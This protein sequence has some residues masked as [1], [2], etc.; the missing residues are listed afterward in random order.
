MSRKNVIDNNSVEVI[1]A[2]TTFPYNIIKREISEGYDNY[3]KEIREIQRYYIDYEQGAV[4][5]PEGSAGDYI[6][7]DVR[8]KQIRML[9]NK[10]A[11]F[12]FSQ[13]PDILVQ[14]NNADETDNDNIQKLQSLVDKVLKKNNFSSL[15]LKS[16]KDCFIGKRIACLVDFSEYDGIQIHFYNSMQ[17]YYETEYDSSRITKFVSF[18]C[19]KDLQSSRQRRFLLKKYE[20]INNIIYTETRLYDGVGKEVETIV[21]RKQTDLRD[22][23][24]AII[25]NDGTLKDTK[26]ISEVESLED[27]ESLF[28]KLA[29]AD[30][31]SERKGMNPTRY[32]IDMN[33]KCTQN[34]SSSAGSYWDLHTDQNADNV[35]PSVG[36]LAP[37]LN[38]SEPLK[39]TLERIRNQ[40]Y[41][42]V[43][44]PDINSESL[45]G[46]VTSGKSMKALYWG[47]IVR[48][49][50]KMIQ[51][52]PALE[53]IIT[54]VIELSLLNVDYVKNIYHINDL[55]DISYNIHIEGNYAL[56]EDEMEEKDT[57]MAEINA[58]ARSRKSY[59]KKW[60]R[61]EF[62]TDEQIDGELQQ[63]ALEQNL[64]DSMT[65]PQIQTELNN[66]QVK[67][68]IDDNIEE[69]ELEQKI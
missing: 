45:A 62:K 24:V 7:S 67:Q 58:N 10:E 20:E 28:S 29:N 42:E 2:L 36:V 5:Y 69:V 38:H 9:I 49:D 18:K 40:M 52:I 39:I 22:I 54:N 14:S 31:D 50:E 60:R 47:L 66:Q 65:N 32:T 35:S 21:E 37:Q 33:P 27:N 3:V 46:I 13:K 68:N 48:C 53:K 63:I 51:W 1:Q 43:D 56:L 44:I 16:A 17:F 41:S 11:R 15:L 8:F 59:I 61:S 23:P 30:V 26:G 19:V 4:F 64:F 12:M 25:L 55:P 34:L 6:P 57:D